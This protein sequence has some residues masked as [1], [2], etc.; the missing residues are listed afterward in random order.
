MTCWCTQVVV[1]DEAH[2]R[3]VHT[4]VLLGVLK[5]VQQRRRNGGKGGGSGG[6]GGQ[7]A[8]AAAAEGGSAD[9][10]T[11]LLAGQPQPPQGTP[12][13]RHSVGPLRL[14]VMS[15]TL[16]AD[17]FLRYFEGAVAAYVK[18]RAGVPALL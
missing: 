2:E 12:H 5:A 14:I 18:V 6:K 10:T 15:A 7:V 17:S 4:D 9:G 1:V 11:A 8:A 3:T 13:L 16:E